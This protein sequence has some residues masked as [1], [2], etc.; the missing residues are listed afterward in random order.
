M[1]RA[2]C[3]SFAFTA[4]TSLGLYAS[5]EKFLVFVFLFASVLQDNV[6]EIFRF[7]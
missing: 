4:E 1:N 2:T 3:E 5:L 6:A 7:T